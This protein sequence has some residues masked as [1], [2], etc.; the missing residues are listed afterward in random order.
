VGLFEMGLTFAIWMGALR[1]SRTTAQV[2]NLI[3]LA[4]FLS[5]VLLHWV[6]GEAIYPSSV[7]GLALIVAGIGIQK[8]LG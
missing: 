4:P 1:L 3:Y 7:A 2:A 8:R 6:V 5:L